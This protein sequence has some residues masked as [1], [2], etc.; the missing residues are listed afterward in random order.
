M[1][2]R[3]F[4]FVGVMAHTDFV[5]NIL[6]EVLDTCQCPAVPEL[7]DF[8]VAEQIVSGEVP[9]IVDHV[10]EDKTF[11]TGEAHLTF[12]MD[13]LGQ[14]TRLESRALTMEDVMKGVLIVGTQVSWTSHRCDVRLRVIPLAGG[15]EFMRAQAQELF[16]DVLGVLT[17]GSWV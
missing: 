12:S 2:H 1:G 10:K 5:E 8:V 9:P 14:V 7:C 6:D 15:P 4:P 16:E 13:E 17:H 3:Q 11:L